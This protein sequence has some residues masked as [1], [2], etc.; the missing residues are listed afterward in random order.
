M[1]AVPSQLVPLRR[2]HFFFGFAIACALVAFLGFAPTYWLPLLNGSLQVAP[3]VHLH[4]ALQFGWVLLFIVQAGLAGSGRLALHRVLG[5]CG[6]MLAAALL[7]F[8]VIA[9]IHSYHLQAA[10]GHADQARAF[11]IAPISNILFFAV[12]VGI[13]ASQFRRPEIHKRLMVLA[14]VSVLVPA[15]AR[16][17][18]IAITGGTTAVA[19]PPIEVTLVPSMVTNLLLVVA[20]VH[21]RKAHGRVHRVYWIGGGLLLATQLLRIPLAHTPLWQSIADGLAGLGV[22]LT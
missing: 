4:A 20:M 7:V 19:P 2:P 12:C 1:V 15:V 14:T 18:L 22:P 21:D 5:P 3:L 17:F 6:V 13:A 16:V 11:M 10:A 9:A 8:G